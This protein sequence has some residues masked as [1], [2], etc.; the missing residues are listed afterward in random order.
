MKYKGDFSEAW[1]YATN[2]GGLWKDRKWKFI[3]CNLAKDELVSKARLPQGATAYLVYG[4]KTGGGGRSNHAA[5]EVVV[6]KP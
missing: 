4:F 3:Q 6:I 2:S 1:V 5:S